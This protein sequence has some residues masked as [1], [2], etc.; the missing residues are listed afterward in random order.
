M[1]NGNVDVK[2][3]VCD[4]SIVGIARQSSR[5]CGRRKSTRHSRERIVLEMI[6]K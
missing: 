6:P 4:V 5:C 1:E 2:G 3:F